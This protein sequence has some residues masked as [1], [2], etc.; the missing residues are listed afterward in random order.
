[1]GP[2]VTKQGSNQYYL[3]LTSK[4]MNRNIFLSLKKE[5]EGKKSFS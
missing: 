3:S 5:L 2:L 1:M 4:S